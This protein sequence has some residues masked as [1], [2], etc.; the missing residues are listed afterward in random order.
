MLIAWELYGLLRILLHSLS[1][2]I[3]VGLRLLESFNI[4]HANTS[5]ELLVEGSALKATTMPIEPSTFPLS[6]A[7][8]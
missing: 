5:V 7:Q 6:P 4:A 1:E 2:L 8:V 3:H